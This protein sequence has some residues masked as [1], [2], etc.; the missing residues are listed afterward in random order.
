MKPRVSSFIAGGLFIAGIFFA[1][2]KTH[3]TQFRTT[4][5]GAVLGDTQ[6]TTSFSPF[7]LDPVKFYAGINEA[8]QH[9]LSDS[10]LVGGIVPHHD[11][12]SE[13]I[14]RFFSA[15]QS[16]KP[17]TVIIV[18]PNHRNIGIFR[19][20]TTRGSWETAFGMVESNSK[21][22]DQLL[23]LDLART[24][25]E[26]FVNEQSIGAI[27][28]YIGYYLPGV[29]ILPIILKPNMD[30]ADIHALGVA[31]G[32]LMNEHTAIAASVD[33]SHDLP[34]QETDQR[35]HIT[36]EAIKQFDLPT[37]LS[38]DSEYLDSPAAIGTL[39]TAMQ[40][41]G[42]TEIKI[43]DHTNSGVLL[44]RSAMPTTSYVLAGFR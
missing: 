40:E 3:D 24:D 20:L 19:A 10:V 4:G 30:I 13:L 32:R 28:P 21:F 7:P 15:L 16:Q 14:A 22:V 26:A 27:I 11:V 17:E 41:N 44:E 25:D 18:G 39:L 1:I 42:T 31:L 12:A 6:E 38:L 43:F 9:P 33:F 2:M 37:L 8:G 23:D 34:A 5:D 29:R 36:I 35:D